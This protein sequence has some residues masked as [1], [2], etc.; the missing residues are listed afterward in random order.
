MEFHATRVLLAE[1]LLRELPGGG[2]G[3]LVDVLDGVREPPL[4]ILVAE[5]LQ[6]FVVERV[7]VG[8]VVRDDE[9][10]EM[11]G[12]EYPKWWLPDAVEYIDEVPKTATGKFSKKDLREQY[13]GSVELH[14]GSAPEDAAPSQ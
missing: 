6:Y 12:E 11:L 7:G 2:L 5:H 4:R 10:L 9:I 14:E 3:N 13:T 8:V 1:I